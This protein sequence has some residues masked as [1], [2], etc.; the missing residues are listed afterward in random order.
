MGY[1]GVWDFR[2]NPT[3]SVVVAVARDAWVGLDRRNKAVLVGEGM[4]GEC[5]GH[6]KGRQWKVTSQDTSILR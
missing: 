3:A 4:G 6:N 5:K 1:Q 2:K